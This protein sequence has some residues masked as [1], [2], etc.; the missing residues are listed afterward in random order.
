MSS[1]REMKISFHLTIA[2]SSLHSISHNRSNIIIYTKFSIPEYLLLSHYSR[3]CGGL[4]LPTF[5]Y[6]LSP[7]TSHSYRLSSLLFAEWVC[8]GRK[9]GKNKNR[10]S[11]GERI[12]PPGTYE[13][14]SILIFHSTHNKEVKYRWKSLLPWLLCQTTIM[15]C[16]M[17]FKFC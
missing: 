2:T 7:H 8:R 5:Y 16:Y 3:E 17:E 10:N 13:I 12:S 4:F 14:F 11:K 6:L 15:T 9:W 1:S